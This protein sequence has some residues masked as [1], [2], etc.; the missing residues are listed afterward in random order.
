M[1]IKEYKFN[2]VFLD[3]TITI[4]AETISDA[5]LVLSK[6]VKSIDDYV[7]LDY[8]ELVL[9]FRLNTKQEA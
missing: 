2:H 9:S 6:A 1:R 5:I 8:N 7:S 4:K 3:F